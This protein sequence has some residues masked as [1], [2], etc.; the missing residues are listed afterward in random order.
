MKRGEGFAEVKVLLDSMAE[1]FNC[2]AFAE[3][4]PVCFPRR[5]HLKQDIEVSAF[6]TAVISW[7]K[8]SIILSSARKMHDLM[9]ASPYDFIMGRGYERLG[10]ANIHRTF[11][12]DDMA[13]ICRGL[14]AV[15]SRFDSCE[16]V[17]ADL[18]F[19][20]DRL[21][22]G[23][24]R[25]RSYIEDANGVRGSKC[26]R[27]I[28]NP[29][30]FSACKRLHLA[31]RWL[32]RRDGIVDLGIWRGLSPSELKIPLDVHVGSTARRLGL[33]ERKQNDRRAVDELTEVLRSFCPEDPIR[34]DFALFGIGEGKIEL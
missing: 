1:R 11:F 26:L 2:P 10:C 30:R 12:E 20:P 16:S 22:W 4:D 6:L 3:S 27:H 18:E 14:H 17:F 34:Y 21:W 28:S 32:V 25:L 5:Y 29:E 8:R 19:T 24:V 23:I 7:G 13:F 31:L 15:Y 33:L 9:G